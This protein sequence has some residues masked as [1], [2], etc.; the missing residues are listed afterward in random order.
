MGTVVSLLCGQTQAADDFIFLVVEGVL[1]CFL[2]KMCA[3]VKWPCIFLEQEDTAD[4][5]VDS[6]WEILCS[7]TSQELWLIKYRIIAPRGK[8]RARLL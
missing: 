1:L 2:F 3:F 5:S 6:P 7:V 4:Q 8:L